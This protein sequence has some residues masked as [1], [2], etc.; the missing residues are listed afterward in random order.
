LGALVSCG[1]RIYLQRFLSP[2]LLSLLERRRQERIWH[3]PLINHTRRSKEREPCVC[4][5][6]QE[7]IYI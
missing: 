1:R 7:Y 3:V 4:P 5:H 6:Q 2:V